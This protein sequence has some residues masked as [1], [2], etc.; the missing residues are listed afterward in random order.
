MKIMKMSKILMA[1]FAGLLAVGCYNDFDMPA[2]RTDGKSGVYTD[3][4]MEAMGLTHIT[5]AQMKEM[6]GT[7]QRTGTTSAAAS[8]VHKH[9]IGASDSPGD[10][11]IAGEYY[12]KGKV[13]TSDEQG[14]VYRSLHIWDGTAAIELKLTNGLYLD[15]P[16]NL[17]TKESVW[18]YVKLTDLYLG[19]YRMMLS[20]GDI[21]TEGRNAYG[22]YK[23]YA[24]SNITNPIKVHEHVFRGAATTL[25]EGTDPDD[26]DVDILVLDNSSFNK[27]RPAGTVNTNEWLATQGPA[28][29]LGRLIKFEG[30]QVLY[31]GVKDQDGKTP[32][33]IK[34][35]SYDQLYPS[36]ICT[37]GLIVDGA[38]TQVVNKPWY[39]WA[40]SQNNVSL[41]GQLCVAFPSVITGSQLYTSY[42]GVY[43]VRTSGYSR[44]AHRNI[45]KNGARGN[46]LGIYSIYTGS[47]SYSNF[48]NSS[49]D[50]ATYQ[51]TASRIED[52]E[53]DD[54]D[55]LTDEQVEALTPAD[56]KTLP[57]QLNDD[58][59]D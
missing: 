34:N 17:D 45:P 3:A 56:A 20:L 4:D 31:S 46:V 50:Q 32:A 59:E 47:G 7:I 24:N 14:N 6:F 15:Y 1:A 38:L 23:Y 53:F 54:N 41:Y 35:G 29:Y 5:I 11:E 10:N 55:I 52:L 40:Y 27:I 49:S 21:P 51:L 2:E 22:D 48:S 13:L 25:N 12:I 43:V 8:T 36:W 39:K 30:V 16:C 18:V 37:S 42:A 44:F 28:K 9:F 57:Q 26:P 19:A 58:Y 33:A